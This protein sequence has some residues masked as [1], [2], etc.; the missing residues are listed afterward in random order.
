[1]ELLYMELQ[2]SSVTLLYPEDEA[3]HTDHL[4]G[5]YLHY[6]NSPVLSASPGLFYWYDDTFSSAM[7]ISQHKFTNPVVISDVV[8]HVKA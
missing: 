4:G 5:K 2:G 8:L 1:M 3:Y 7:L 6:P